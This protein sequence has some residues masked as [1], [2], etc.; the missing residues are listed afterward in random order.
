[1][2]IL[3]HGKRTSNGFTLIE[4]ILTILV[5]AIL[6]S[7]LIAFMGAAVTRSADPVFQTKNLATAEAT[8]EKISL[9]YSAHLATGTDA[10][11]TTFTGKFTT[12]PMTYLYTSYI[13][14]PKLS[15]HNG[16]FETIEATVSVGDHKLVSYFMR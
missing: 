14:Y 15:L 13:L 4:L 6:G 3:I 9:D 8:M 12:Y 10:S 7:F 5:T 1:M 2:R 16:D 11:W